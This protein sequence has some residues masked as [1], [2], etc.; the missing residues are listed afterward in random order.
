[1]DRSLEDLT[2]LDVDDLLVLL[3]ESSIMGGSPLDLDHKREVGKAL[4]FGW[5]EK[6]RATLCGSGL[7]QIPEK[8]EIIARDAAAVVDM[9]SSLQGQIPVATF[10]VLVVKYG[11]ARL[12]LGS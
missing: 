7:G 4:L 11:V 5:F 12:C 2:A 6:V 3:A 8:E 1:V 9:I 10:A